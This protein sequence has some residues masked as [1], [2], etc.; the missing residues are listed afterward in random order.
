MHWLYL[1]IA[2]LFEV[3]GTTCMKLSEGFTRLGPSVL[4]FV[5]YAVSFACLTL[6][7]RRLDVSVTYAVWSGAGTAAIA[8]IGVVVF[9]ETMT[10]ARLVFLTLIVVGVVGLNASG[11]AH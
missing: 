6:A 8:L 2:I 1:T 7:L 10:A 3:A 11:G 9:G 4:L 5:C